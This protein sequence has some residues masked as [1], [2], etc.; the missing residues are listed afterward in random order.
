MNEQEEAIDDMYSIFEERR[1]VTVK[2]RDMSW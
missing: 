2:F 1:R